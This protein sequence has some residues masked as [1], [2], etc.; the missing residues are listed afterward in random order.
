[1]R[2]GFGYDVHRLEEGRPLILG[3]VHV[4]HDRG[5]RGHSDADALMHAV[6]D[7][8][9]GAA[10]LGDLGLHFPDTDLR[11]AGVES[12][13]LLTEVMRLVADAGYRVQNVDT[14]VVLEQPKLR[15]FVDAM[16]SNLAA[17]MDLDPGVVSVKATRGEAM[18]FVG[19]EEGAAAFA[20][21]L[22]VPLED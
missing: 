1:M 2:I 4:P 21:C 17:C 16:R 18:G 8:L 20:V 10:A 6:A 7:A 19:R 11:F 9:L 5:L 13:V 15:P 3:G 12:R 22:I 14:T